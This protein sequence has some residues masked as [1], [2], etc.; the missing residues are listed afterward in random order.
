[1]DFIKT[2][3]GTLIK[4]DRIIEIYKLNDGRAVIV[5]D[6]GSETPNKN[7]VENFE[8]LERLLNV[9]NRGE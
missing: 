5:F 4:V 3:S 8:D 6:D 2:E 1:M 9:I 7:I